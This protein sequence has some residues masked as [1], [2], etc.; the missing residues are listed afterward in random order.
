LDKFNGWRTESIDKNGNKILGHL[1]F[2]PIYKMIWNE[3]FVP[4]SGLNVD[5]GY[6]NMIVEDKNEEIIKILKRYNH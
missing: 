5:H 3:Y 4:G 6:K 2:Q 1:D